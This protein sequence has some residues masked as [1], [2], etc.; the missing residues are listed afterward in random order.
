MMRLAQLKGL[1]TEVIVLAKDAVPADVI[2]TFEDGKT[3]QASELTD[4]G[5]LQRVERV[6]V[7]PFIGRSIDDWRV[8]QFLDTRDHR[9]VAVE[10]RLGIKSFV[11]GGYLLVLCYSKLLDRDTL[12]EIK[13]K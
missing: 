4:Y 11:E 10:T 12:N 5:I 6:I 8:T 1:V 7:S 3:F 13:Q 9:Y 2:I